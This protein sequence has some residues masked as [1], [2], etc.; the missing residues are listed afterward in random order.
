MKLNMHQLLPTCGHDSIKEFVLVPH[1]IC[2]GAAEWNFTNRLSCAGEC[3]I[4]GHGSGAYSDLLYNDPADA[5]I[6]V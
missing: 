4:D 2:K 6:R 3:R 5:T 1:N